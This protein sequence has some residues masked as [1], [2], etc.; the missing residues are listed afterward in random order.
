MFWKSFYVLAGIFLL[1][2]N[3][4]SQKDFMVFGNVKPELFNI[5]SY[6]QDSS[7]SAIVLGEYSYIRFSQCL[8]LMMDYHIRILIINKEG[9]EKAN[10]NFILYKNQ[11]FKNFKAVTHNLVNGQI[12][13]SG[14]TSDNIF[15]Q[16]THK[17]YI[18]KSF[19][20]PD[21]KEGCIIEYKYSIGLGMFLNLDPIYFQSD[22]PVIR[23]DL[24]I[25]VP[26]CFTYNIKTLGFENVKHTETSTVTDF[27]GENQQTLTH[28][29]RA[30]SLPGFKDEPY[31]N[32]IENY[33][34]GVECFI[35][36]V[37]IPGYYNYIAPVDFITYKKELLKDE[38]FGIRYI[39]TVFTSEILKNLN[40]DSLSEK[41]KTE[42]IYTF[43]QN[44]MQWN[45]N[46][47]I[48]SYYPLRN[49]YNGKRGSSAEINL[50]LLALLKDA[51]IKAYPL[52]LSSRNSIITNSYNKNFNNFDYVIV[53]VKIDEEEIL[54]DATS[55]FLPMDYLPFRCLNGSGLVVSEGQEKWIPLIKNE[56]YDNTTYIKYNFD[57][58]L[59]LIG[60]LNLISKNLSA[61]E[62]KEKLATE[63]N[64]KNYTDY[65][66]KEYSNIEITNSE[67]ISDSIQTRPFKVSI[68]FTAKNNY[69]ILGNEIII[70]PFKIKDIDPNPF[71]LDKRQ[72]PIDF[73]CPFDKNYII[74]LKIPQGY[75]VSSL[76]EPK[77]ASLANNEGSYTYSCKEQNGSIQIISKITLT[78]F[79][80]YPQSNSLFKEFYDYIITSQNQ[81]I[82]L[83]KIM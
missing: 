11:E 62:D 71:Y 75:Q 83:K 81:N 27:C 76:P 60:K 19:T 18:T 43:V 44:E 25:S 26:R 28:Y 32:N 17:E 31:S 21:I 68:D 2:L 24:Y 37:L 57:E 16:N 22:I 73:G 4:Y 63:G 38:D 50:L 39:N 3:V 9:F 59:K 53:Y 15:D 61:V 6:K 36:S 33:L 49:A 66:R 47:D 55:K 58:S 34:T 1:N 70:E 29:F 8:D 74:T 54:L 52:V 51:N 35:K 40:L 72:M 20:L 41:A 42:R 82:I 48:Y 64:S 14:I 79:L 13:T 78:N 10:R 65:L 46:Y 7:V 5:H 77:S 23:N 45:N 12:I 80:F 30:D 69:N 67:I 56:K